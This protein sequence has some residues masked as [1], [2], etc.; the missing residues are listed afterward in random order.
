M[1][2]EA[3]RRYSVS[4]YDPADCDLIFL[5]NVRLPEFSRVDIHGIQYF[6]DKPGQ[7]SCS[8]FYKIVISILQRHVIH[9]DQRR[10][11]R[12]RSLQCCIFTDDGT[13]RN[14]NFPVKL[15]CDSLSCRCLLYTAVSGKNAADPGGFI[16][17]QDSNLVAGSDLPALDLTLITAECMI[18]SADPLNRK[19]KSLFC[20]FIHINLLQIIQQ[21]CTAVPLHP[22]RRFCDIVSFCRG[23]RNY[24][25]MFDTGFLTEFR[26]F[27]TDFLKDLL[28]IPD[29]IH[30]IY[31]KY[32]IPDS[33]DRT[34]A[35]MPS[36]LDQHAFRSV[37][38][39]YRQICRRRA[40]CHIS[41]ILFVP[42]CIRNNK[43]SYVSCKIAV[44]NIYRDALLPL[45]CQTIQK[46]RII[47]GAASA[48]RFGCKLERALLICIQQ[49]RIVQDMTDQRGFS[50][51]H[52][53]AC[54]K[55][56]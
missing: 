1:R 23:N 30:F 38:Q 8:E 15:Q 27:H 51:I 36:G 19:I 11:N 20:R 49:L 37:N 2:P 3:V 41:R 21:R 44:G 42:R 7:H 32:K 10:R 16:S 26:D 54:Y 14:I 35:R 53:S 25:S 24:Y 52:T 56:K 46:Q 4:Q 28:V 39:Y 18:R 29:Q 47:D 17:R 5:Q 13:A 48:S 34:D 50:V 9:P 6:C 45:F 31:G 22:V 40:D 55:P 43:A 33:H 12:I